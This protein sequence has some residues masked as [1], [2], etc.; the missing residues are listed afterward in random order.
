MTPENGSDDRNWR[1][2]NG[3]V[4]IKG[5]EVFVRDPSGTGK[6][7]TV[8]PCVGIE[9]FINGSKV[10][11]KTAVNVNDE[12]VIK[13]CSVEEPGAYKITT[14]P[15]GVSAE[16]ELKLGTT[17]R[18]FIQ[19]CEPENE[20]VLKVDKQVEKIC[21]CDLAGIM[22]EMAGKNITYGIKHS[23]IQA[24]LSKPEDGLYLIAEGDPPGDTVDGRVELNFTTEPEERKVAEGNKVN[25]RD[26]VEIPSVDPGALLAV[27]H[28]GVQGS[29]GRSVTGDIIPPKKPQVFELR[30]GK[31]VDI[32]ADGSQAYAL[33]SGR[34]LARRVGNC[35]IID[36][37]P[38]LRK[39]GDVDISSGNI[40]FKGD[41]IINGNVYEGMTVQAVGRIN[42]TGMVYQAMIGAQGDIRVGRNI[43]GG[44]VVAGGNNTFFKAL[45]SILDLLYADLSGAAGVV[46]GLVRH[47]RIKNVKVG[48]LVQLL[49]DK[50]YVRVPRLITEM[51]KLSEQNSFILPDGMDQLLERIEQNLSGINLLKLDSLDELNYLLSEMKNIQNILDG[52]ASDKANITFSY[53]VNT[54]IEA[55]GDVM[56]DGRG[57][58][59][60][61]IRAGG[62]VNVK[63]VFRGGEIIAGGDVILN[64][65]GSEVGARTLV[66]S[67][68][69]RK[70]YIKK[71]FT[72][73]WIRIGAHRVNITSVQYNIMAELDEDGFLIM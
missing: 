21:P 49:I 32:S 3:E 39:E 62:N 13:L 43:T 59:N 16:L 52:M 22:Q 70:I 41:V 14:T 71:A 35:Y 44:S 37:D 65:V 34:P 63:G 11:G 28:P 9:L 17:T 5:G 29:P 12:I 51:I 24:I 40:R 54:R 61:F 66:A 60:T 57:C 31:G 6:V 45:H 53:A 19:D 58:I 50:K 1:G 7:P 4:W 18:Y 23:E 8:S 55:S 38:V 2:A 48:Q 67:R 20:L 27:K 33:I 69:G 42:I 25:L 36:I 72:G 46:P 47:P 10:E 15:G 64:E 26:M 68:D 30:G 73:V 56:V